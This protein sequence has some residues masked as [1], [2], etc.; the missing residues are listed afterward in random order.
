MTSLQKGYFTA[1]AAE[2]CIIM[3]TSALSAFPAVRFCSA[4]KNVKYPFFPINIARI[5][6]LGEFLT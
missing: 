3:K 6:I 4:L 5:P 1:E 2:H